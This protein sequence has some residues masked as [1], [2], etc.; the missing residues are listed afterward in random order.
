[1][2]DIDSLI[3]DTK[4]TGFTA[5]MAGLSGAV[6]EESRG[7]DCRELSRSTASVVSTTAFTRAVSGLPA[8]GSYPGGPYPGLFGGPYSR[9]PDL[10]GRLIASVSISS[11]AV[12]RA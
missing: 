4:L 6:G 8:G 3:N 11:G 2:P 9:G 1:M 7:G 12:Q 5:G 10:D